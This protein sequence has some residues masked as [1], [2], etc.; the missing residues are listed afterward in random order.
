MTT[1][2]AEPAAEPAAPAIDLG[3]GALQLAGDS[4]FLLSRPEWLSIQVYVRNALG[5]PTGEAAMHRFLQTSADEP[6]AKG[7]VQELGDLLGAYGAINSHCKAWQL[8][9]FPRSVE[10]AG[11]IVQYNLEVPVAYQEL[12]KLVAELRRGPT[13]EVRQQ[14]REVLEMLAERAG[15][16]AAEAAAVE[17]AVADFA[18]KTA[19]DQQKL[20]E[21]NQRY[22]ARFGSEGERTAQLNQQ[23]KEQYAALDEALDEYHDATVAA[24]T[25]PTY[26]WILP[27]VGLIPAIIVAGVF[28]DRAVKAKQRAD[29]ARAMIET[30]NAQLDRNVRALSLISRVGG[31]LDSLIE[32][33][34]AALP[35]IQRIKASW[36]AIAADLTELGRLLDEDVG[37]ALPSL[38]NLGIDAAIAQ[39]ADVA[40]KA[41]H[42]RVNAYIDVQPEGSAQPAPA[43]Q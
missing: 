26:A 23:L 15:S 43:G 25:T 19:G 3:P 27:P 42:Y 18:E 13:D 12:K 35:I 33:L 38:I 2:T 1:S 37:Q 11:R 10:L 9:T 5:L 29:A 17:A 30:L 28:S 4:P 41:N 7:F 8:E 34:A 14:F 16:Y 20:A 6:E 40:R 22:D 31:Q 36:G 24:A 21:L 32:K 39:W